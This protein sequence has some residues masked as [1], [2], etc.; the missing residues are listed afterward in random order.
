M[1]N[2]QGAHTVGMLMLYLAFSITPVH[3][4]T[5]NA[6]VWRHHRRAPCPADPTA[7]YDCIPST[8]AAIFDLLTRLSL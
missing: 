6:E 1:R 8:V 7:A 3:C 5:R 2:P 4:D